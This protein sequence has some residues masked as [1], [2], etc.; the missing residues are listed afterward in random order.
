MF[1]QFNSQNRPE[2]VLPRFRRFLRRTIIIKL[3]SNLGG[4]FLLLRK[5]SV[6][7]PNN[8][9]ISLFELIPDMSFFS[10]SKVFEGLVFF[11][12]FSLVFVRSKYIV[13]YCINDQIYFAVFVYNEP[14]SMWRFRDR[15]NSIWNYAY[16]NK[17]NK[18]IFHYWFFVINLIFFLST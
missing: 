7:I 9:I 15:E 11:L 18:K 16:L 6:Y 5:A 13:S 17:K 1:I 8:E 12:I 2:R 3:L 10:V 14:N 4:R